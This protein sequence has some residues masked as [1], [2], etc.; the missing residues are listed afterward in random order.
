MKFKNKKVYHMSVDKFSGIDL[1]ESGG[2]VLSGRAS[3]AENVFVNNS[4]EIE[5]RKGYDIVYQ[6]EENINGIYEYYISDTEKVNIL[7]QGD[8]LYILKK[9]EGRYVNDCL[10]YKGIK[11]TPSKG[12]FFGKGLYIMC[13][14]YYKIAYDDMF[15]TLAVGRVKDAY[16]KETV[17]AVIEGRSEGKLDGNITEC[18]NCENKSFAIE[19]KQDR[20]RFEDGYYYASKL[21]IAPP[22]FENT[23][24]IAEVKMGDESIDCYQYVIETDDIGVFVKLRRRNTNVDEYYDCKPQIIV[25]Y[26]SFVY[27][28]KNII[29]RTPAEA[30]EIDGTTDSAYSFADCFNGIYSEDLNL[31]SPIRKVHF[32]IDTS[33]LTKGC[34][35]LFLD[36]KHK[37]GRVLTITV[38]GKMLHNYYA[39]EGIFDKKQV[40]YSY[41]SEYVDID[42]KYLIE[43]YGIG[44]YAIEVEFFTDE[45][46]CPADKCDIYGFY[47]GANDL[48]VFISGNKDYPA[49]DYASGIFDASYFPEGL[50]ATVGADSS[51][52]LG[53]GR[54]LGYQLI[55]KE[56]AGD[57][58]MYF[59]TSFED[60]FKILKSNNSET[61]VGKGQ[62]ININSK[63]FF[64]SE[65]GVYRVDA[66]SV[67]G[68]H[69]NTLCSNEI[70]KLLLKEDLENTQLKKSGDYLIV[71]G[72]DVY[73]LLN[74]KKDFNWYIYRLP[75]RAEDIQSL[76]GEAILYKN[77]IAK[78]NSDDSEYCYSDTFLDGS[79]KNVLGYWKT[80]NVNFMPLERRDILSAYCSL[81]ERF[82]KSGCEILYNAE[83]FTN[84]FAKQKNAD[85][86]TF[87]DIDFS[88]FSFRCIRE[89]M[90]IKTPLRAKRVEKFSLTVQNGKNEQMKINKIG[91][92]YR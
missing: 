7:H 56:D 23:F 75:Y 52:I 2:G 74:T 54:F 48:R 68:Q 63:L 4:G 57:A 85:I 45:Y 24:R 89:G 80:E 51:A 30:D 49:R 67:E 71:M 5:K 38:A 77:A 40:V 13:D 43:K 65:G 62:V 32:Y 66:T 42:R 31:A 58:Q 16:T 79:Q 36:D 9:E 8:G 47:D 55:F 76:D 14:G 3:M 17:Q 10:I 41:K 91:F 37:K 21:Y 82:S 87:E 26:N 18:I 64:L 60:G 25:E 88:R 34:V 61:V 29:S 44:E 22:E 50:Y 11:D 72:K 39:Q 28:P 84:H 69:K 46:L 73:Y 53:Y 81:S 19:Y 59:R 86:F 90:S 92:L 33:K 20:Y 70:N 12:F 35:R 83:D 15:K 78:V 1:S 6:S 27:A